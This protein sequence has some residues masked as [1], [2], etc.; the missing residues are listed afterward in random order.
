MDPQLILKANE[1]SENE[2]KANEVASSD[3]EDMSE[4]AGNE[5]REGSF[6]LFEDLNNDLENNS[7]QVLRLTHTKTLRTAGV[8][9][10]DKVLNNIRKIYE[11][12]QIQTNE[13]AKEPETIVESEPVKET[14]SNKPAENLSNNLI[15]EK[16]KLNEPEN[17]AVEMQT[18]VEDSD[19]VDSIQN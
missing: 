2:R 9:S 12:E 10:M 19:K 5:E 16:E 6:D 3:N 11:T 15:P 13:E 7:N 14:E 17:G 18:N 4:D 8:A 1:A